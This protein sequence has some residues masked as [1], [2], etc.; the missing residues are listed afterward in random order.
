MRR[1]LLLFLSLSLP[2]FSLAQHTICKPIHE[3]EAEQQEQLL[4]FRT[5]ELTTDYDIIYNRLEWTVDPAV[6]YIE[7]MV[8]A[9]FKPTK[10]D[11]QTLHLDC[12]AT[13]TINAV[14]YH[15]MQ[16]PSTLM[17]TDILQI[18]L[19]EE[20]AVGQIDSLTISYEGTPPSSGFGSFNQSTHNGVPI[21]WTL[22]EP[23]GSKD[24]WPCKQD[25]ND[26][27][28][29][30]DIIV[31]TPQA[32]RAASNG[33]LIDESLI[34]NDKI[35]H[36][37]HRYP[38]PAY[39]VAIAVTN[40]AEYSD[41]VPV[42]GEE[43]IEVL[44]Y[45]YPE[46]MSSAQDQTEDII[47]MMTLFNDL[48]GTYPFADE[49]YGHAQ[50]AWGGGMEHQ[51]MSFM[52]NFSYGL[53]AH[54]LAHQWFGD[55]VTCGSWQDIWLNEGFATYLT[56]LTDD[57]LGTEADWTNWKTSKINH[58][59]GQP[60]GSVWVSD[61]NS[62]SRIF[63]GR[64][65]YSKGALV[66]HM[67]RWKLGDEHF[68]QGV[69]NYLND[70]DIAFG[71]ARTTDLQYHLENQSGQDLS[72]FLQDW[73]YGQGYPS[74]LVKWA[75]TDEGVGLQVFQSTSHN[76]VDFFEMPLPILLSGAGQDSLIRLD[77]QANGEI[78]EIEL[79]FEVMDILFDPDQWILSANNSVEQVETVDT[80]SLEN[81][82]QRVSIFPNPVNEWLYVEV[83]DEEASRLI[84]RD[85]TGK[86]LLQLDE[87]FSF[88][89]LPF[90]TLNAGIY[91]VEVWVGE[92]MIIKK[93]VKQ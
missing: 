36:W 54:E 30:V 92:E 91:F 59:T 24:W 47:E 18:D 15:G 31:R 4:H 76:S 79:P 35:Y 83:R 42:P 48:F 82:T 69:Q 41:F 32:Y 10:A 37:R 77:H 45:V 63:N 46:T 57:F 84:V 90:N 67:L 27:I 25:L 68:F 14:E 66:L 38:I 87:P 61:T 78:F 62:I 80:Q 7:G 71:Y 11:F 19:P 9:Y 17:G 39:L 28:D 89:Q 85:A 2:F 5:N 73:F 52:G 56:G 60:D 29:S 8:T 53:Q 1:Y 22:S 81:T 13:L 70:P 50:F 65:S 88:K 86:E 75:N 44:N 64:L 55:K 58:V 3:Q 72:E 16:I 23:Y 51:T 93:I 34:G 26:K 20:I 74:Y 12:A 6:N 43:P 49:K 40:Y 33:V 21:L